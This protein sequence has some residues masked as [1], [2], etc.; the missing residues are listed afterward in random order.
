MSVEAAERYVAFWQALSSETLDRL[1][2]FMAPDIHFRDP[3]KDLHGL[4]QVTA[5]FGRIYRMI[6][7]VDITVHD[8]AFGGD[9][10]AGSVCYLRWTFAYT[11]RSGRR[12]TI[13]GMS[14]IRF[15]ADGL[16]T[17][18]IDQWDAAGQ[19]YEKL[20]LIGALLRMIRRR[21]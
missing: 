13:E 14:E 19:V 6:R 20:P 1:P 9:A 3:F 5:A 10:S 15:G 7:D 17:E 16:A 11:L 4:P 18:H 12:L 21:I 2:E 8:R